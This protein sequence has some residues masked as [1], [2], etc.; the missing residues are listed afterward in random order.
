MSEIMMQRG[1]LAEC[2]Q[3]RRHADAV[4]RGQIDQLRILLDP[5]SGPD[6]IDPERFMAL[7]M[8]FSAKLADYKALVRE[9][10][11]IERIL[12]SVA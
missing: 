10:S 11:T 4:L 6:A 9:I 3:R 12:G 1:R 5:I 2:R 7:A 8:E